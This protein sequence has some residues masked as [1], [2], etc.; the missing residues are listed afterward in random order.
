M[1]SGCSSWNT[2]AYYGYGEAFLVGCPG[3]TRV[4]WSMAILRGIPGSES[5]KVWWGEKSVRWMAFGIPLIAPLWDQHRGFD[6]RE[7]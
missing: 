3:V 1:G 7:D 6:L 4:E 2:L 5:R